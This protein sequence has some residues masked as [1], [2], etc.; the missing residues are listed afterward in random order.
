MSKTPEAMLAQGYEPSPAS[1]ASCRH[2]TFASP[3]PEWMRSHPGLYD[4]ARNGQDGNLRCAKGGFAVAKA[5]VCRAHEARA[6]VEA[7]GVRP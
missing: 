2:V 7:I 5:A 4:L 1:C 6:T 3:L